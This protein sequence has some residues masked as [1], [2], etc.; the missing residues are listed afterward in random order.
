MRVTRSLAPLASAAAIVFGAAACGDDDEP[1]GPT[2]VMIR[3]ASYTPSDLTVT[4]GE[5]VTFVNR[6]QSPRSAKDDSR[7]VI[8]VSPQ[9]GPTKHDGSEVNRATRNGFATHALFHKERQTVIFTVPMTYEYQSAFGG[10][11]TGRITVVE[12]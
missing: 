6:S 3:D 9:P 11:F 7:G 12:E 5:R 10:D 2:E 4:V 1:S 8:D